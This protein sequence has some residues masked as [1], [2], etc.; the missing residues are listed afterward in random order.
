MNAIHRAEP[1]RPKPFI[2][3][4][5][6][7]AGDKAEGA[8]GSAEEVV[9][10][11]AAEEELQFGYRALKVAGQP[12]SPTKAEMEAHFP[13]HAEYRS[14]CRW[15]VEGKAVSRPHVKGNPDEEALGNVIGVDYCFWTAEESEEEMDAILIG[16]DSSKFGLW[17]FPADAKG[18][19]ESAVKWLGDKIEE[20]GYNSVKV[21]LKS[22]QE[23]SIKAL[24]KAVSI[25]RHS[26]TTMIESPVRVSKANG[27]IE[28]AVRTFQAQFRTLRLYLQDK[29]GAKIQEGTPIMSWLINFTA[30][31]LNRAKVHEQ[32]MKWS[33]AIGLN[34]Q[35]ADLP[36]RSITRSPLT[37]TGRI[38]WTQSGGSAITLA[39]QTGPS[40]I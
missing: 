4:K 26:E 24:K 28:R 25:K 5:G 19:T 34:S 32:T 8:K 30:D 12:Y 36:K 7:G 31:V 13:L 17:A 39:A 14:W 21:I 29:I 37:K 6:L 20:S 22:D 3:S 35:C 9:E 2:S 33:P 16:Y 11:M 38:K 15:C 1:V 23:E 18:A 10:C 27:R 40:S